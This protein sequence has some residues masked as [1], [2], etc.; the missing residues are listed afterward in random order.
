MRTI[1]ELK[2]CSGDSIQRRSEVSIRAIIINT[3]W[4]LPQTGKVAAVRQTDE[5][6]YR[7]S[8][9]MRSYCG[10]FTLTGNT[11]QLLTRWRRLL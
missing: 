6:D 2:S 7:R 4:S 1:K 3:L 11:A 5:V 10:H 8:P 9:W